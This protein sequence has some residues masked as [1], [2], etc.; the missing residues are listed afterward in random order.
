MAES[1]F[2]LRGDEPPTRLSSSEFVTEH[3]FQELLARFPDLLTDSDFGEGAARR[4]VLVG[5]ETG[6]PSKDGGAAQWSLDHLFL[7]QDGVPTLVEVKRATDTRAR[8]EVVAQM[9]DYAANAVSW[10]RADEIAKYFDKTCKEAGASS[11]AKLSAL[12]QTD[13]PD[14]EAFW[15]AVQAN[16]SSGRIRMIFV[17][18]QIAPELQRII[19]FLNEQMSEA[20]VAGLELRPFSSGSE[21]ILAPRIIGATARAI[22]QKKVTEAAESKEDWFKTVFSGS[23]SSRRSVEKFIDIADALGASLEVAGQSLAVDYETPTS[24]IRAAYIRPNGK[25]AISGWMLR[26]T[27]AFQSDIAR[28][29]LLQELEGLGF[30]LSS[31]NPSGEPVF[32][33]PDITDVD[34]WQKLERFFHELVRKLSAK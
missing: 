2:L 8:R 1:L 7:D 22:A 29:N 32:D 21:R 34:Q 11:Y 33:L 5:R 24:S 4:W 6:V 31:R 15:R 23:D 25:I 30:K 12:L 19:E 10:W 14:T 27:A 16:L 17:A 13:S 26:K 9:L 20:T 18:D 3:E 28:T